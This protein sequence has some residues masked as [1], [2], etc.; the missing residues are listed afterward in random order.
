[1]HSAPLERRVHTNFVAAT[2]NALGADRGS[3]SDG[4]AL[5][6]R[7]DCLCHAHLPPTPPATHTVLRADRIVQAGLLTCRAHEE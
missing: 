3:S 7:H 2:V 4:H 5:A 1:M 6:F